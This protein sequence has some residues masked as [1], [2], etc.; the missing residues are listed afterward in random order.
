MKHARILNN[1]AVDVVDGD[2]SAM[3][4][5]D[6]AE[7]F[8]PVPDEVVHGSVRLATIVGGALTAGTSWHPP[9]TYIEEYLPGTYRYSTTAEVPRPEWVP[10]APVR[11]ITRLA[12]MDRLT[13]AEAISID[14]ASIGATIEAAK[15]RRAMEKVRA[16]TYIDLNRADTRAGVQ[17]METAGLLAPGRAAEILDAPIQ[18]HEVYEG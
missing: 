12:F 8:V 2:P 9:R 4:A 7:V 10:A 18:A 1:V 5:P 6:V 3:F 14:L 13:D 16:A 17:A 11:H 15:V